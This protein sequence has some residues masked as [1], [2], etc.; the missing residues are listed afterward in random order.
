MSQEPARTESDSNAKGRW[1]SELLK[2]AVPSL[3]TI[4]VGT[5]LYVTQLDIK[6]KVDS[7]QELMKSQLALKEEFYKRRLSRYEDACR[8]LATA[9]AALNNA[10][11]QIIEDET[12][13]IDAFIKF[14]QL[15]KGNTIYW[16]RDLQ[17]GLTQFWALGVEKLRYR[18]WD[19]QEVNER[20]NNEITT[21]HNQM[22]SD[23]N[24]ADLSTIMKQPQPK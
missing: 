18:K 7:N 17:D 3:I 19:D 11:S 23:L 14:E 1:V 16:S 10:G 9:E 12:L 24:V 4:F 15:N 20:I 6:A 2:L 8:E 22:K 5:Y 21:L 13:A